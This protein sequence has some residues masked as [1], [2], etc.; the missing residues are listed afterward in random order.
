MDMATTFDVVLH[1]APGDSNDTLAGNAGAI[2]NLNQLL[3]AGAGDDVLRGG[4]GDDRLV[5]GEGNDIMSGGKGA[6]QFYF[7]AGDVKVGATD[8]DRIVDL[9]FGEG[10][11]LLLDD[12]GFGTLTKT[13]GLNAINGGDDAIVSSFV[14]IK[15]LV[16]QG[17]ATVEG[18]FGDVLILSFDLGGDTTQVI[19]LSNSFAAYEAAIV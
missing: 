12:F 2:A 6:D 13:D 4:K 15:A 16:D 3:L 1:G 18:G 11:T 14:G 7:K 9:N 5:G 17:V 10:D 8:T 19:R